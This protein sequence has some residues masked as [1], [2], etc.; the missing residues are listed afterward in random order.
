MKKLQILALGCCIFCFSAYT[1]TTEQIYLWPGEVPGEIGEKSEPVLAP[2][3][4]DKVLRIAEVTNPMLEVFRP[5][6]GTNNGSGLIVCPGGGYHYLAVDKEGYEI[7]KWLTG[8]G[9]TAFVLQYRVPD[10]YES[11]LNDIQRAI[12]V[13]RSRAT[14]WRL[15]PDKLGVIGFSAGASLSAR[16]GTA[17]DTDSYPG[18]DEMDDV[19]CRPDFA[20]LIY[21]GLMDKGENKSL[22][23]DIIIKSDTPPMFIFGTADD[24]HA[25]SNLVMARALREAG[26]PVELHLMPEGGHGYGLRKGN[27]AAE[28]WPVLARAWLMRNIQDEDV[29]Y[30]VEKV[31][32]G[33]APWKL[34][35]YLNELAAKESNPLLKAH[36][37]SVARFTTDTTHGFEITEE[38]MEE[39]SRVLQFFENEGSQWETYVNGSRPLIIA[40]KSPTDG[41]YSYYNLFLPEDFDPEK[42]DYPF[43]MELHG[44]GG[45]SNDNPRNQLFMSLQPEIKGVTL[46]GYRKEGLFIYPW[47]RGDKWYR[48]IAEAD[49][50]EALADFD[51][52][53]TTDPR[54]QYIYGFSMGGGGAFRFSQGTIDR[55]TAVGIYSGAGFDLQEDEA[56]KF[57][58]TPVWMVWGEQEERIGEASRALK[59]LF[60]AEGVDLYWKE[61]EG[62][63]HSYLGEY[64]ENL[65]DWFSTKLKVQQ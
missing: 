41:K 11:A 19:S 23:P 24:T 52:R 10:K 33:D 55:W 1:Q 26:I 65:M 2:D 57:K 14:E 53:F 6:R 44:S 56:A 8:L 29:S 49:I 28:T 5:E 58:N 46:Q 42:T 45:G 54:K 21:A 16:A 39:A 15:N 36:F 9:Y 12:R 34:V 27:V 64:Q 7:A 18:V 61:I 31:I 50:H 51:G 4:G 32:P 37:E 22:S 62:V 60:L 35:A 48:G 63:G 20:L 43:Y 38:N 25:N 30:H 47:G 17:F 3:R 59:D 13:V 40:F